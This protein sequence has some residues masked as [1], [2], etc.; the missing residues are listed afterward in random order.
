MESALGQL[1]FITSVLPDALTTRHGNVVAATLAG[2]WEANGRV[3]FFFFFL[4][5]FR[6]WVRDPTKRVE[7]IQKASIEKSNIVLRSRLKEVLVI[8]D[9][10]RVGWTTQ[11]GSILKMNPLISTSFTEIINPLIKSFFFLYFFLNVFI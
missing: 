7:T 6:W 8:G 2:L 9:Q 1:F 5:F 4:Y 3:C 11:S 10:K